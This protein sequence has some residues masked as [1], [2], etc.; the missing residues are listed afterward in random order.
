MQ[1]SSPSEAYRWSGLQIQTSLEPEAPHRFHKTATDLCPKIQSTH[2][3][4]ILFQNSI[5]NPTIRALKP[6]FPS[7]PCTTVEASSLFI[8]F[9]W[10]FLISSPQINR[11]D[12]QKGNDIQT[13][14]FSDQHNAQITESLRQVH[15]NSVLTK[16]SYLVPRLLIAIISRIFPF[17]Y[18]TFLFMA[19]DLTFKFTQNFR[20][21][22]ILLF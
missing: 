9:A 2:P 16:N 4:S 21:A 11:F 10:R 19:F 1:H 20:G 17:L 7:T 13:I 14:Y 18:Q 12:Y 8:S 22:N 6:S 5:P 15:L 3:H